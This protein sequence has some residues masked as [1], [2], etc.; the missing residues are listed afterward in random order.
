MEEA[1]SSGI[2][3]VQFRN[4][5]LSKKEAFKVSLKLREMTRL[6]QALYLVND[7]ID[8]ALASDADGVH[9][10]QED[11][12]LELAR[13]LLGQDR[14]IGVSTHD[15]NEARQAE[16]GGADYI[17]FGS[18]FKTSNKENAREVGLEGLKR[19]SLSISI[20]ILAIGG[21]SLENLSSVLKNGASGAAL[22][23]AVWSQNS[24][25]EAVCRLMKEAREVSLSG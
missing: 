23:S 7:E 1:L 6:Y 5:E 2:Q 19:A 10:G 25:K 3:A 11:F 13:K 20:P 16:K 8:L 12:P 22:I 15:L 21:I 17:G 14:I 18:I 4:K 24:V 9:I